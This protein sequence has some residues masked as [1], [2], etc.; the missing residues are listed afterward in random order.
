MRVSK[1]ETVDR[2]GPVCLKAM[3]WETGVLQ[4]IAREVKKEF[5][6]YGEVG[7]TGS[8]QTIQVSVD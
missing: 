6:A 1:V 2:E 5:L 7:G 4:G 8:G 3:Y